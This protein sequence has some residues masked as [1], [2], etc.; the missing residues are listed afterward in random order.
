MDIFDKGYYVGVINNKRYSKCIND[1]ELFGIIKDT[2]KEYEKTVNEKIIILTDGIGNIVIIGE[3]F[4][5]FKCLESKIST[6]TIWF[7]Q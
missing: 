7:M 3:E 5:V 6:K 4:E 2:I 1:K